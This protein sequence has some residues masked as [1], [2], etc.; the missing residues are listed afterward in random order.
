MLNLLTLS[1]LLGW[2]T[3]AI[4]AAAIV[5]LWL[6]LA[7][8][9]ATKGRAR[10][11]SM[12]IFVAVGML[13]VLHKVARGG[14]GMWWSFGPASTSI[15][16][17]L[18]AV[19]FSFAALRVVDATIAVVWRGERLVD[20]ISLSGYIL[21]FHMLPAGPIAAYHDHVAIDD[22]PLPPPTFSHLVAS[23]DEITTGLFYKFV[24][25]QGLKYLAFGA[26]GTLAAPLTF[27]DT[28]YLLV[29]LFFDFAG[30]SRVAVGIGGLC[31][32]PTPRNFHAPFAAV[33]IT[34]FWTRWHASLSAFVRR[35]FYLPLQL[36]LVRRLGRERA[37]YAGLL[38]LVV[39]FG[40]VGVWH[41]IGF[42]FLLWGVTMGIVMFVEKLVRDRWL[43]TDW[44]RTRPA[45]IALSIIGPVYVF[46]TIAGSLRY[47][48]HSVLG[49][50]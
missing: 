28:A 6:V 39:A 4:A 11:L 10:P 50:G 42:G 18:T 3:V 1:G 12:V 25:A 46:V 34:D 9:S 17:V 27:L 22:V 14:A 40:F 24:I 43:Q 35:N 36:R 21:P 16:A 15:S 29:Y 32:I 49:L 44:I 7:I 5:L 38:S 30:Y 13:F 2:R 23:V 8:A 19:S 26:A 48:M 33:S 41:Q 31:G 47:V 20:P 37:P 45:L